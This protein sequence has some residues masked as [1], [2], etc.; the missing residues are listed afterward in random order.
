M[1]R[2]KQATQG[3]GGNGALPIYYKYNLSGQVTGV[4]YP[5]EDGD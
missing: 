3:E 4:G 2:I 5:K 1:N